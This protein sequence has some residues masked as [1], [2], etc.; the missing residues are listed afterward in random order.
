MASQLRWC[1][2]SIPLKR[3]G[4]SISGIATVRCF[5][6]TERVPPREGALASAYGEFFERL[7]T[8][9][10]FAEYH[11]HGADGAQEAWE[12]FPFEKW[13]AVENGEIPKGICSRAL[14]SFYDPHSELTGDDLV[15]SNCTP[16][17]RG[18]CTLP[19]ISSVTLSTVYMP[20]NILDNLYVSNGMAAGNSM[21]EAKVQALSEILERYVKNRIIAERLTLSAIPMEEITKYPKVVEGLRTLESQG[22]T[23]LVMDASLG[24]VFPVV[25]ITLIDHKDSG[26]FAAFGA[27]PIFSVALERTLTELLQG[28][29]LEK[30][31]DFS[32]PVFDEA[33]VA[34]R[35]N[36]ETHFIDS[37]G[38]LHWRYFFSKPDYPYS[39]WIFSG[40]REA[41]L[42]FLEGIVAG[43]GFEMFV[44]EYGW[45]GVDVCR[46]II[47]GMSEIYP[48]GDLIDNNKNSVV[49]TRNFLLGVGTA[50]EEACRDFYEEFCDEGYPAEQSL[51]EI[52]GIPSAG[53]P[54][55]AELQLY[56]ALHL[57]LHEEA[58]MWSESC[59]RSYASHEAKRRFFA[60]MEYMLQAG[61]EPDYDEVVTGEV[62]R[63]F[64]GSA[65]SE[66]CEAILSGRTAPLMV[67]VEEID[68]LKGSEYGAFL[69]T[70]ERCRGIMQAHE[71]ER[72]L[73][74]GV[75]PLVDSS[76]GGSTDV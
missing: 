73:N 76:A 32:M 12:F 6:P 62:A 45:M 17:G 2:G 18:I 52:I 66:A 74:G 57:S 49:K 67:I 13:F 47:P 7:S 64:F 19:F 11:F 44:G 27:H 33:L 69:S 38:L 54:L 50:S 48:V 16:R 4:L 35:G 5:I 59:G 30:L 53:S 24:G 29:S 1:P 58:L 26:V 14:L 41:E 70:R 60:C 55:V 40:D 68:Q 56:L 63:L 3:C 75:H 51:G 71:E 42:S 39:Q 65:D 20:V 10:F 72:Q 31:K 43:C 28:R 25:N 8:G 36:L 9:Y 15:D 37:S 34:D 46:I 61:M 22:F 23:V 21:N